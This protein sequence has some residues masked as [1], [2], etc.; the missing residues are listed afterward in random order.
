MTPK[1]NPPAG[2]DKNDK[3]IRQNAVYAPR[4]G[5]DGG[6]DVH[7]ER[8]AFCG[9]GLPNFVRLREISERHD[10]THDRDEN[11]KIMHGLMLSCRKHFVA[12]AV[13]FIC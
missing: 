10:D 7:C 4:R 3:I 5:T 6:D 13:N 8:N 12:F 2:G 11:F 9:F 1:T